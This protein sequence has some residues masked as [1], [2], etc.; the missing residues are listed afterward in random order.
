MFKNL[1]ATIVGMIAIS[2]SAC[3]GGEEE[4]EFDDGP[5]DASGVGIWSGTYRVDGTT[6]SPPMFGLV[7]EEGDFVMV[8]AGPTLRT[9]FGTGTTNGNAFSANAISYNGP[10]KLPSTFSGTVMDGV[11][12]NGSYSLTGESATFSLTYNSSYVRSASFATLAG[13]YSTTLSGTGTVLT[14]DV[15][16]TGNFVYSN[17]TS[18]C[19]ITGAFTIP[20][21]NRN[22]YRWTGTAAGCSAGDSPM[23]GVAYLGDNTAGQNRVL[24]VLGQNQVQT[25]SLLLILPK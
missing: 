6:T 25:A 22:Y 12:L 11:S 15:G 9:F 19:T 8:V 3:G 17:S 18:G 16:A 7:T 1:A 20:H 4:E 14:V 10:N 5:D 13:I 24:T 23:S 2:L 21:T